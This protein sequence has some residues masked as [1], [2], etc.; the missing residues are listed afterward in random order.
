MKKH[1]F[2][3]QLDRRKFLKL[4]LAGAAVTAI[5]TGHIS[6]LAASTTPSS[7]EQV[8]PVR[9]IGIETKMAQARRLFA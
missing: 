7:P 5:G 9:D 4:G 2:T 3:P 6:R 1:P 8:T